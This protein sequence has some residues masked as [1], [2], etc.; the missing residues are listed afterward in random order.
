M[1]LSLNTDAQLNLNVRQIM[2]T[3]WYEVFPYI[4]GT[5][6][7]KNV[8]V[9]LAEIQIELSMLYLYLPDLA[10]LFRG[11]LSGQ[12]TP[13]CHVPRM[14]PQGTPGRLEDR[15]CGPRGC[16]DSS[17]G[18]QQRLRSCVPA[19]VPKLLLVHHTSNKM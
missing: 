19:Y 11:R 7:Y 2:H 16:V 10:I 15:H 6:S 1:L 8:R 17:T 13:A 18:V 12:Q 3:F 9:I 5:Y 14:W 4:T